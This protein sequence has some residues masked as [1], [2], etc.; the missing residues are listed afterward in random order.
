MKS[1]TFIL[2]L[3]LFLMNSPIQSKLCDENCT[4][5][6]ETKDGCLECEEDKNREL[7]EGSCVCTSGY[8]QNR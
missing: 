7:K 6:N 4:K 5:C 3:A 8:F 1:I 2:I